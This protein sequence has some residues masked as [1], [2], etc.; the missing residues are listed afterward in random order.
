M[1]LYDIILDS[2]YE[3]LKKQNKNGS[4]PSWHN[5]P[6]YHP[7]TNIRNTFHWAIIFIKAYNISNDIKFREA[8]NK[9]CDFI[10]KNEPEFNFH[11]RT[12]HNR[13]KCNG[14]MWPAWAIESL[15]I[16]SKKLWRKDL[17]ELAF[18]IFLN[19]DFNEKLWLWNR[20]EIDWKQLPIDRTFNHQL[21]FAAIWS[22][23]DEK[24]IKIRNQV[25]RFIEMLDRNF[26][27]YNTWLVWHPIAQITFDRNWIN[28]ILHRILSKTKN[29]KRDVHKA[30]GYHTFNLYAFWI[31]KE[32]YP[33]LKFWDSIK[34]KKSL[35]FIKTEK[36]EKWLE[37]NKYWFDYNVV[38]IETA[39]VL[40][41]FIP[42]SEER[43]KYW[44]EKQ[45]T[46]N[47]DFDKNLLC[48]NT[49]DIETLSARLY[50]AT[51]LNNID[52]NL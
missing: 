29:N 18:K 20:R 14:T 22:M 17:E 49:H 47:Y 5:W 8:V 28:K 48:R 11:F 16:I 51:R 34:F 26:D 6:Y 12:I 25:Q 13:D 41:S 37:N 35:D 42:N 33:D 7:E 1:K 50:E 15:L 31:L 24:H 19:H 9:I 45:F 38:W 46:K 2:A 27:I 52:L 23:F 10:L 44:L 39:Y 30:I 43:Q 32:N 40:Q 36:F 4:I 21:W 3:W